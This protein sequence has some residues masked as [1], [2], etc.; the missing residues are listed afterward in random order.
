MKAAVSIPSRRVCGAGRV[1]RAFWKARSAA[2]E[3]LLSIE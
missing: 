2:L 3:S 1:K